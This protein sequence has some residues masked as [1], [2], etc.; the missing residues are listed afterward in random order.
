MIEE[1]EKPSRSFEPT[2]I[3]DDYET[4]LDLESLHFI[5]DIAR[6]SL[7]ADEL[8]NYITESITIC[9]NGKT[10]KP[11]WK[12]I[13]YSKALVDMLLPK[14]DQIVNRHHSD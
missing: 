8:L 12:E 2:M 4:E 11:D 9:E 6:S 13:D 7:S 5:S 14:I 3:D 10:R 1:V